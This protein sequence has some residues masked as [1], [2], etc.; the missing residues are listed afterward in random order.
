M[1]LPIRVQSV[2]EVGAIT[3]E[4]YLSIKRTTFALRRLYIYIL[5][6]FV[7]ASFVYGAKTFSF[8][9]KCSQYTY[10]YFT[11]FFPSA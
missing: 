3:W 10:I 2:Y 9:L 4:A 7:N 11:T 6:I 8:F 1:K 5:I